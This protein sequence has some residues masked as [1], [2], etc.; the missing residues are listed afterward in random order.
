[1]IGPINSELRRKNSE[2]EQ[3]IFLQKVEEIT[4]LYIDVNIPV[5]TEV[6]LKNAEE[7][8]YCYNKIGKELPEL[9]KKKLDFLN[10]IGYIKLSF[11]LVVFGLLITFLLTTEKVS[12]F[13]QLVISLFVVL[14]AIPLFMII[15]N[16]FIENW[17]KK[18]LIKKD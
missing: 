2:K 13:Y 7:V 15:L 14:G 16:G 11:T 5:P 4:K 9:T 18:L 10:K 1:M 12:L 8:A 3:I 6:Q 17:D